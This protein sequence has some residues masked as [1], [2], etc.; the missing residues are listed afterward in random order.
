[1]PVKGSQGQGTRLRRT[2]GTILSGGGRLDP[3]TTTPGP[4][5][6][7]YS[8]ACGPYVSLTGGWTL[9]VSPKGLVRTLVFPPPATGFESLTD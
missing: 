3:T 6:E 2:V 1:M 5:Y 8:S 9:H 7:T 4:P